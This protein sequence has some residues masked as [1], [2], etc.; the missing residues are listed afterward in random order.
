MQP[1]E[2]FSIPRRALDVE[3]YIDILRRHKGWVFGPFL[4][5]LVVSVVGAFLWPNSYDSRAIIMI[6][7]QQVPE[8]M[9]ASTINQDLTSRIDA[10]SANIRSR[11][12]LTTIITNYDLYK[13]EKARMPIEDIVE[14]MNKKIQIQPWS[15]SAGGHN[16]PAFSVQFTYDNRLD[17]S[18]VT[19]DLVTRF[20]DSNT[21]NRTE[22][23]F[24]TANFLK[25]QADQAQ[26][27]LTEIE[28][29]LADFRVKNNGRLPDQVEANNR[30]LQ[31]LE[32]N[33]MFLD[34]NISRAGQDKMQI[35]TNIRIYQDSKNALSKEPQAVAAESKSERLSQADHDVQTLESNLSQ[36]RQRYGETWPD[37]ITTKHL[38]DGAKERR[39]D[40]LKEETGTK[41]VVADAKGLSVQTEREI[42]SLQGE[43]ER[44]QSMAQAKDLEIEEDNKLRKRSQEAIAAYQNRVDSVPLGQSEYDELLRD[45]DL[46]KQA[47]MELDKK[48]TEAKLSQDME[49]SKQGELLELLDPPSVPQTP[50]DPK[51]EVIIPIGAG[52]GLLLG[53][54]IAGAR[55]MKDSSLKNLKDVRAYTQMAI[56]GSIP[57]L[58][59]DFVVR[60]RKRLAWLGWTMACLAAVITMAGSVV[61][62]IATKA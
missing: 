6:K 59:N 29:R 60:R 62:Y 50:T 25:S 33:L 57:L 15:V 61:Y 49:T 44:L 45:R 41:K 35:E 27:E 10:M 9:V 1:T 7:P 43:I 55:E 24:A 21:H 42:R 30:T 18:K 2:G 48:L 16:M 58:E 28:K 51:R 47:Y 19:G 26:K 31:N 12:V 37:V 17:A 22:I 46:K 11:G 54:V 56:L 4:L 34:N 23:S 36:L 20:I 5:T 40:I 53:V 8:N 14:M 32:S 13:R 3:D 38:L 39:D 52:L